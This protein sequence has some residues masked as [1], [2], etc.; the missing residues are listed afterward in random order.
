M[1]TAIYE[2]SLTSWSWSTNNPYKIRCTPT[3]F[4]DYCKVSAE[5]D[6]DGYI[7]R[8]VKYNHKKPLSVPHEYS[9]ESLDSNRVR[10]TVLQTELKVIFF[11]VYIILLINTIQG[12]IN[13]YQVAKVLIPS[14]ASLNLVSNNI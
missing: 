3:F 11:F 6:H 5:P 7:S 10:I 14:K 13:D 2:F 12:H 9:E 8:L 4:Q 1:V